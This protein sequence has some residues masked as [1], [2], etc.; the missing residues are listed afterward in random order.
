MQRSQPARRAQVDYYECPEARG[1][2]H[3]YFASPPMQQQRPP[4]AHLQNNASL[5]HYTTISSINEAGISQ[6]NPVLLDTPPQL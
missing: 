1:P 4:L 3:V 6:N 5:D 2:T